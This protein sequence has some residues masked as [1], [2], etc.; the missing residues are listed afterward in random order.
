[1][2]GKAAPQQELLD[3]LVA[4]DFD[5]EEYDKQMAAAFGD[6]YYDVGSGWMWVLAG[7]AA[8]PLM[9]LPSVGAGMARLLLCASAHRC[10]LCCDA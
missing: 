1:M 2:A 8:R 7:G 6:D 10:C 3:R 5:P 9:A 4:G